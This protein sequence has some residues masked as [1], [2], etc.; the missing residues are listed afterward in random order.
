METPPPRTPWRRVGLILLVLV[1]AITIVLVLL[2]VHRGLTTSAPPSS[3]L[4]GN[5]LVVEGLTA[6]SLIAVYGTLTY[7]AFTDRLG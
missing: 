6:L 4:V 7:L 2:L 3:G 5:D 1:E